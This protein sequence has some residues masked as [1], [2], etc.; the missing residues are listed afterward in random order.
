MQPFLMIFLPENKIQKGPMGQGTPMWEIL[1]VVLQAN[2]F[3]FSFFFLSQGGERI[4]VFIVLF[5]S[6]RI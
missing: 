6:T 4:C 3:F 2:W 5:P 1:K